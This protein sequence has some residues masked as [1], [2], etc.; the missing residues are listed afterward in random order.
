MEIKIRYPRVELKPYIDF[1]K[2]IYVEKDLTTLP[3]LD[4][5]PAG[6]TDLIISFYSGPFI[7]YNSEETRDLLGV[8]LTGHFEGQFSVNLTGPMDVYWIRMKAHGIFALTGMPARYFYDGFISFEDLF[9]KQSLELQEKIFQSKN[10]E[11]KIDLIEDFLL[12]QI[13][14]NY[15]EDKRLEFILGSMMS[16]KGQLKLKEICQQVGCNYKYLDR[17]FWKKVGQSPKRILQDIRFKHILEEIRGEGEM[18]WMQL[19]A[20]HGFHD[21][22]H[23]IKE[24][25]KYTQISPSVFVNQRQEVGRGLFQ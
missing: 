5:Y 1:Y 23:F 18:D 17:L 7:K 22:A 8:T 25:Q 6:Y 12:E 21:Q 3:Q 13:R 9:K 24:F 10:W 20:D 14:T 2:S 15:Q 11:E 16:S 4:G 19:V